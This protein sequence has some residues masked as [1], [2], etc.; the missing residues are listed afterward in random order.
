[1]KPQL[2]LSPNI[3]AGGMESFGRARGF[4]ASGGDISGKMTNKTVMT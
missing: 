1:M 4:L 2:H 3:P